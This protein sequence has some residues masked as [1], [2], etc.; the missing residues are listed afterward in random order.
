MSLSDSAPSHFPASLSVYSRAEVIAA[1]QDFYSLLIKLPYISPDALVFPPARGWSGVNA[2]ELRRRGKTEEVVEL[3]QHLPYLRAPAPFKRWMLG[4]D[5]IEI[6][7][8]DGELYHQVMEAIQPLPAH[9]TWL[10]EPHSRDGT[11]LILDTHAGMYVALA[12]VYLFLF[13]QR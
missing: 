4:P 8:C 5:T 1:V 3:L 11:G 12:T 13:A 6:A 2:E 7:Y 9:C 10:T